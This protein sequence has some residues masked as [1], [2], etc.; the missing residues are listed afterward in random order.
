M[1]YSSNRMEIIVI[2]LLYSFCLQTLYIVFDHVRTDYVS[3]PGI[4]RMTRDVHYEYRQFVNKIINT[5]F[6]KAASFVLPSFHGMSMA[7]SQ[8]SQFRSLIS[9]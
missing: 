4:A 6:H 5:H 1:P 7:N 9:K 2:F 3:N 8:Y